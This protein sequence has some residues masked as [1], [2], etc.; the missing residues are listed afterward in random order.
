MI[1]IFRLNNIK[2]TFLTLGLS[3]PALIIAG[4]PWSVATLETNQQKFDVIDEGIF[5]VSNKHFDDDISA[6]QDVDELTLDT[7][8]LHE[9][10]V[11][12]LSEIEEKRY[13]QLMQNKSSLYYKDKILSPTEI[14]GLNARTQQE[15]DKF[16]QIAAEQNEQ[17]I[18]QLLAWRTSYVKAYKERTRALITI[19]S[20]NT[21]KYS[22]YHYKAIDL[23]SGDDIFLYLNLEDPVKAQLSVLYRLIEETPN[24]ILH[25][26][27]LDQLSDSKNIN[28]WAKAHNVPHALVNAKRI[29][30][31]EASFK[32]RNNIS[33]SGEKIPMIIHQSK[34]KTSIV[35][36][37]RF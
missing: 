27:F 29:T 26:V 10:K 33:Q 6:D 1:K 9:A 2:N 32:T 31:Q 11:W 17:Q 34:G 19:K 37:S 21:A 20:F 5:Q 35:S 12:G 15:R 18:A 30:L 28:S 8:Q 3:I 14:L 36:M 24:T 13:V 25:L 7:R 16:A 4:Q 22:P 23:I